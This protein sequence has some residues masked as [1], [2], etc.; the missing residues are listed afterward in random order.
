MTEAR[1]RLDAYTAWLTGRSRTS[2]DIM[3]GAQ[4]GGFSPLRLETA[5]TMPENPGLAVGGYGE[6]RA[7]YTSPVFTAAGEAR[8]VHLGLDL[9]AP[10][11]TEVFAPLD[12]RVHSFRDNANPLDYGP[13]IILEHAVSTPVSGALVFYTLY[14]H[15]ARESLD[16]LTAGQAIAAG[17]RL[18]WLGRPEV[19]GGW[20]PHLHVQVMLDLMGYEG[21]FP[22]VARRS[23]SARWLEIC[24]DP[25]PL[26]GIAS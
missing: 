25:G 6:D 2:A 15:L 21:D 26:L 18:G 5:A 23:E 14:G 9:F 16:G 1:T 20:P 12:G 11:G 19:N 7:I 13:T 4:T 24:P 10:A 3:T 17:Q 8:T 22:G